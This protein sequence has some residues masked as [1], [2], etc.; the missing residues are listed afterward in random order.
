[1][2]RGGKMYFVMSSNITT[3]VTSSIK[4]V[5]LGMRNIDPIISM[6]FYPV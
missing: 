4:N 6:P 1:L 3:I 2:L 5:P